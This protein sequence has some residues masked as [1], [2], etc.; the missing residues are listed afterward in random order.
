MSNHI[1]KLEQLY[2]SLQPLA[3]NN[4][5]PR[6]GWYLITKTFEKQVDGLN[7]RMA[8]AKW[9]LDKKD[10]YLLDVEIQLMS[11]ERN[12]Y[13]GSE[14]FLKGNLINTE[15]EVMESSREKGLKGKFIV[16]WV[17]S[18]QRVRKLTIEDHEDLEIQ[19]MDDINKQSSTNE[20]DEAIEL[21]ISQDDDILFAA[22]V[23]EDMVIDD[24]DETN[25]WIFALQAQNLEDNK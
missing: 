15:I 10:E 12:P 18:E 9:K 6:V 22:L 8:K 5:A 21:Q 13:K 11:F 24:S 7:L 14:S 25:D 1:I 20:I 23:W 2:K 4:I 19:L 3:M 17:A 16:D